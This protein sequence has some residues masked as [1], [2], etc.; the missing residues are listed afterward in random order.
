[1]MAPYNRLWSLWEMLQNYAHNFAFMIKD[2]EFYETLL[3]DSSDNVLPSDHDLIA[4]GKK[5]LAHVKFVCSTIKELSNVHPQI[6]RLLRMLDHKSN[7]RALLMHDVRSLNYRL[8]DE[9]DQIF[10]LHIPRDNASLYGEKELFGSEVSE[11]FPKSIEDIESA[12]QCLA[13]GQPTACVFHLMRVMEDGVQVFGRKLKIKINVE[14]ETWYQI[15]QHVDK[16]IGQMPTKTAAQKKKKEQRADMSILLSHVRIA[17]RN[18]VMHP[19]K[20]Y[21]PVEAREV[22]DATKAFMRHLAELI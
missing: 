1:M 4:H 19:K 18:D 13:V 8:I 3:K 11:K 15:I 20:T 5:V 16:N 7:S 2:L 12:G 21:T 10:F 22:F 17:W 9:L 14:I 6:D